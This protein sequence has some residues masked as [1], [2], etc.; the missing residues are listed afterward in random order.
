MNAK[1]AVVLQHLFFIQKGLGLGGAHL[2]GFFGF[3]YLEDL[4][5]HHAVY[6]AFVDHPRAGHAD[7]VQLI[8]LDL[9]LHDVIDDIA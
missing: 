9:V 7:D 4:A 1:G 6:L 5:V 2:D 8:A 3:G